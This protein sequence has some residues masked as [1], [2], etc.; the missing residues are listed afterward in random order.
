MISKADQ[1]RTETGDA[2]ELMLQTKGL[3]AA[4]SGSA[5]PLCVGSIPIRAS[6]PKPL[7]TNGLHF[8]W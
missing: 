2:D 4:F 7:Q 5:K 8:I 1:K 3:I 6:N